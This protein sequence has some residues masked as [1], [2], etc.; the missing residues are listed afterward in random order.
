VSSIESR[1]R[2]FHADNPHVLAE[3][4]YLARTWFEAGKPSIGIGFLFEVCRWQRGI[5]T[6]SHDDFRINNDFRAHYARMLI[7]RNPEWAD[8]IRVRALRTA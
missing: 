3:L 8:R 6:N 5:K 1:F 7:A 2:H 4:E